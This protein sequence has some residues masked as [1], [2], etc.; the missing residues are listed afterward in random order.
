MMLL[1]VASMKTPIISSDIP[2]NKAVFDENSVLFFKTDDVVDLSEKLK[3]AFEQPEKMDELSINAFEVLKEK[4]Q[5]SLLAD[6]YATL[7]E[8]LV[9]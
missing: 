7:Y 2:E 4:Y 8:E 3:F 1:E 9:K 5:W 6:K